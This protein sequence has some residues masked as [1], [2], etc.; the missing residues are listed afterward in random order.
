MTS[1]WYLLHKQSRTEPRASSPPAGRARASSWDEK[2][3]CWYLSS[4]AK[5]IFFKQSKVDIF[6]GN[7]SLYFSRKAK[8]I[9][10]AKKSQP[11]VND[12]DA[13]PKTKMGQDQVKHAGDDGYGWIRQRLNMP[14]MGEYANGWI[15][16]WVSTT[17]VEYNNGWI[18]Q[19]LNMPTTSKKTCEQKWSHSNKDQQGVG[20]AAP[21][22]ASV[23][24]QNG[25]LCGNNLI[26]IT[27]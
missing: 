26:S 7:Q 18:Q 5:F 22:G 2:A 20:Q 23:K 19:R 17:K 14:I 4:K 1:I 15:Q 12:S 13:K 10:Q 11:G 25:F 9:L 6:Q 27:L 8:L 24:L 16:Q 21:P 3:T